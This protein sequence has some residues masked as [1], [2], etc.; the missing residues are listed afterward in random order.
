MDER[1]MARKAAAEAGIGQM[2]LKYS[3]GISGP[4]RIDFQQHHA[5]RW[6]DNN[7]LEI[8]YFNLTIIQ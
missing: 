2:L 3:A 5:S 7:I 4:H 1:E 6:L 8:T